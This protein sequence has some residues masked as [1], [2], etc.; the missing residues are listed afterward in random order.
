[1]SETFVCAAT[2]SRRPL[3]ATFGSSPRATGRSGR[4]RPGGAGDAPYPCGTAS[5][6][7]DVDTALTRRGEEATTHRATLIP[8]DGIGPEI[9]EAARRVLDATG[10]EIA[11][12]VVDAG[13]PDE[14]AAAEP[15]SDAVLEA[16]RDTGVALKGPLATPDDAAA[17]AN[18]ALRTALG[19]FAGVRPC[20]SYPGVASRWTGVD[21]VIVRELT[22]AE[23]TGVEFEHDE[24]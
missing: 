20:R 11:W 21:V 2:I 4:R 17:N 7:R 5:V 12:D 8:G 19:L 9:V 16:I 13:D 23:Y 15:V 22:E 6:P 1:M 24:P 3:S 18:V 10:V 14:R